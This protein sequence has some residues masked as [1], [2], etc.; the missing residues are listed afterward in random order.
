MPIYWSRTALQLAQKYI[1]T[2]KVHIYLI[3]HMQAANWAHIHID[4]VKAICWSLSSPRR[5]HKNVYMNQQKCNSFNTICSEGGLRFI[6]YSCIFIILMS[7]KWS[8]D[9][10][11]LDDG[12]FPCIVSIY[13]NIRYMYTLQ[14]NDVSSFINYIKCWLSFSDGFSFCWIEASHIGMTISLLIQL[15]SQ[16]FI[17]LSS[18]K[19]SGNGH[20]KCQ[21]EQ[22]RAY[23][24]QWLNHLVTQSILELFEEIDLIRSIRPLILC[25]NIWLHFVRTY[26][27][28]NTLKLNSKMPFGTYNNSE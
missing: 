26:L 21:V 12:I 24:V 17:I 18:E 11:E 14:A 28:S 13:A 2:Y 1:Y 6:V 3:L 15:Y 7:M 16:I 10:H 27:I 9:S 5:T 22:W 4:P 19:L 25:K 23:N 8:S 20:L